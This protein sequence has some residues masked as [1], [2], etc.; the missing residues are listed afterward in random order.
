[1]AKP[2]TT[3]TAAKSATKAAQ[4]SSDPL[5]EAPETLDVLELD[6]NL[7]D[8]PEPELLPE[9][10][11]RA[12]VQ[13]VEKR[14]NQ[15][16][17]GQYYAVKFVIAPDQY[18]A[19]YDADNWPDGLTLYYNLLRYPRSGDRRALANVRKFMEK[20]GLAVDT[21]RIDPNEWV[22]RD[23]RLK[24]EH[25]TWEGNKREQIARNGIQVAD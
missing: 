17:T 7:D 3:T 1:M 20:L 21:N 8:Y 6:Q 18:P 12:E 14:T 25:G 24:I 11:Y 5:D 2:K 23:A 15:A 9:G 22:G 4:V 16:G 10:W 19:D 13:G